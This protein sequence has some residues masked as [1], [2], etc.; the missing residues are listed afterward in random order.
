MRRFDAGVCSQADFAQ[1][2]VE[3]WALEI[4]PADLVDAFAG[5]MIGPYPGA[6]ALVR[7]TRSRVPVGCLS[8]M[9]PLHWRELEGWP[10]ISAFDHSFISCELGLVKPDPEI[11]AHAAGAVGLTGQQILFL[12]DNLINVNA[13]IDAGLHAAHVRGVGGAEQALLERGI[14]GPSLG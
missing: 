13:A 12:D 9:N 11:Y 5:W 10:L 4:T 6:E 8:N 3:E 2:V 7:R 1:G 14:V